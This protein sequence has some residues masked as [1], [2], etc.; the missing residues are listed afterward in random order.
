VVSFT[1]ATVD[2]CEFDFGTLHQGHFSLPAG[3]TVVVISVITSNQ[4]A[5]FSIRE[6]KCDLRVVG[7]PE[8]NPLGP[9]VGMS[10]M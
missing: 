6:R 8:K 2:G 7:D 3:E 4:Q 9:I 10:D 5:A 1:N